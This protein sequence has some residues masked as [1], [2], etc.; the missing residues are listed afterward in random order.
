[1]GPES[2]RAK[3]AGITDF[4]LHQG[5]MPALPTTLK[6]NRQS[7]TQAFFAALG[8]PKGASF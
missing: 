5:L 3:R 6:T 1:L 2:S 7:G 4:G 8:R